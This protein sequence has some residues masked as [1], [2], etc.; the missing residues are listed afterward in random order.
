MCDSGL[1]VGGWRLAAGS[2]AG[3]PQSAVNEV[4]DQIANLVSIPGTYLVQV[5]P[6]ANRQPPTDQWTVDRGPWTH[7]EGT[8]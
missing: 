4:S 1:A 7:G 6:T 5:P 3:G 8:A 2:A